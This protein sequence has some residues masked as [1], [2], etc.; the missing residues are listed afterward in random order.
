MLV[1]VF[2]AEHDIKSCNKTRHSPYNKPGQEN[3]VGGKG[4]KEQVNA[5]E[6]LPLL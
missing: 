4:F 5:S 1:F 6:A 2:P 3:L